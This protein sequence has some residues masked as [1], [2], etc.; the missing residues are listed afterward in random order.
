MPRE[1]QN[2]IRTEAEK[3]YLE[4]GFQS[5]NHKSNL[6]KIEIL[7]VPGVRLKNGKSAIDEK[8]NIFIDDL[9]VKRLFNLSCKMDY[10][11]YEYLKIWLWN[12]HFRQDEVPYKLPSINEDDLEIRSN[13]PYSRLEKIYVLDNGFKND[14]YRRWR[15][16]AE[17]LFS[18][19]FDSFSA[20]P[21]TPS[22]AEASLF[23]PFMNAV[24]AFNEAID[25]YV[26]MKQKMFFN[27]LIIQID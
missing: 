1:R 19:L 9:I 26:N 25:P 12:R 22:F 2:F 23:K 27:T 15:N 7:G 14:E 18:P 11:D 21:E 6:R 3:I 13:K 16:T 17:T 20:P 4:I 5:D 10:C 8:D 24:A